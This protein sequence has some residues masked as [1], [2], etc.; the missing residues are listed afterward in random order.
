MHKG[1]IIIIAAR[2]LFSTSLRQIVA[3]V[4]VVVVVAVAVTV[5]GCLFVW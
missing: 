5:V 1:I 2:V 3:V 4:V